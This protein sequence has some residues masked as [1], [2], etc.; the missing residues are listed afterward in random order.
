MGNIIKIVIFA[1]AAYG[2]FWVTQNVDF[3]ALINDTT[4]KIEQEKTV[5]RV[6]G[7]RERAIEDTKKIAE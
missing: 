3:N 2:I 4:Q 7:G 6:V 1:A 5:T